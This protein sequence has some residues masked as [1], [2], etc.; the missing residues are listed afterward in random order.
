[1]CN[2]KDFHSQSFVIFQS[3]KHNEDNRLKK[4]GKKKDA[5]VLNHKYINQLK[6]SVGGNRF[7]SSASIVSMFPVKMFHSRIMLNQIYSVYKVVPNQCLNSY[8]DKM[9]ANAL[10]S[11]VMKKDTNIYNT[12]SQLIALYFQRIN[13]LLPLF[14][15][16]QFKSKRRDDVL[17]YSMM[18]VASTQIDD[19][20]LLELKVF[21]KGKLLKHFLPSRVKINLS[22][23]QSMVVLL[24]GLKGSSS[25]LPSYY[26]SNLNSYCILLGLH[27]NYRN[28]SEKKLCYSAVVYLLSIDDPYSNLLFETHNLWKKEKAIP[29]LKKNETIETITELIML[30]SSNYYYKCGLFYKHHFDTLVHINAL[31]LTNAKVIEINRLLE[32]LLD[33]TTQTV[34]SRLE[35]IKKMI[36]SR[37]LEDIIDANIN[38]IKIMYYSSWLFL[39]DVKCAISYSNKGSLF[40]IDPTRKVPKDPRLLETNIKELIAYNSKLSPEYFSSIRFFAF[41]LIIHATYTYS[42]WLHNGDA[43]L[44]QVLGQFDKL[45]KNRYTNLMSFFNMI[46]YM[47][48]AK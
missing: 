21:L 9:P 24:N 12:M 38:H 4:E 19:D 33:S 2:N 32:I 16:S 8:F 29:K 30:T 15:Y 44:K 36:S 40:S 35:V 34:L 7:N 6:F 11:A 42:K 23:I 37:V 28:D 45:A 14:T 20:N 46:I 26:F 13:I 31:N 1:M 25:A 39:Y 48:S 5:I 18:L 22:N 3:N 41:L 17:I 47:F 43:L 27:Q 10:E